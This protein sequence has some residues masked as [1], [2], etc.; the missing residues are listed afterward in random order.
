MSKL[1]PTVFIPAAELTELR[2]RLTDALNLANLTTYEIS[3]RRRENPV[4]PYMTKSL[5]YRDNVA[6]SLASRFYREHG[7]ENIEMAMEV[8]ETNTETGQMRLMTTRHCIL[9]ELGMCKKEKGLG[10]YAEPIRLSSGK[11]SFLLEFNCR[12][13]EMHVVG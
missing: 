6:N 2:R 11:Q 3:Y 7:V 8:S 5:D 1:S 9:R 12:D 10:R 4:F 13:C